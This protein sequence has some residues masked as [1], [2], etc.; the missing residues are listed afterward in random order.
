MNMMIASDSSLDFGIRRRILLSLLMGGMVMLFMRAAALLILPGSDV[1]TKEKKQHIGKVTVPMNRGMIT[2]R[3]G[4]P[5]AISTPVD[6]IYIDPTQFEPEPGQLTALSE[7]VNVSVEDIN[8]LAQRNRKSKFAYLKRRTEPALA[9]RVRDLR[10]QGVF[11]DREYKRYYPSGEVSAH[12]VG[13]NNI[14]DHGQEGIELAWEERL[15]GSPGLKTVVRDGRLSAVAE[16]ESLE[17]GTPGK[18]LALTIDKRLQY[19]A[20][21][22]LKSAFIRHHAKAASLVMLDARSGDVLAM[23]NQPSFNPNSRKNLVANRFRNRAVTD[24]FEP[25]STVK[26]FVVA[27]AVD[28]GIYSTA[29]VINTSPGFKK[30]EGGLVRDARNYG[31]LDITHILQKSSNVGVS[32]IALDLKPHTFWSCYRKLGFGQRAGVRFPGEAVGRLRPYEDWRRFEQATL[33]F[34]YGLSGSALQLARAYTAIAN[35]GEMVSVRLVADE[36]DAG[37]ETTRVM[38]AE[39]AASVRGMLETVVSREGTAYRAAVPGY[40][41]AGKTGTVKKAGPGGYKQKSYLALFA[42]MAPASDPQIVTVVIVDEPGAGEFYGGKV[43]APIFSRVMDGAL[44][45]LGIP[46]DGEHSRLHVKQDGSI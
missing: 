36:Q 43:A 18:D 13:F 5:L 23:V 12:L 33:S 39:T 28:K 31:S 32:I 26:P 8:A 10:I 14:D 42:G 41:I 2:D 11:F 20:Y 3:Y 22:E 34:G 7:L 46:P 6:S 30:V 27:C 16:V 17:V 21:R 15:G 29:A 24:V 44:R 4:E 40:R 38:S 45:L 25:G 1:K 37:R 35:D 19:L 9:S